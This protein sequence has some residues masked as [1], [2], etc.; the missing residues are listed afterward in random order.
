MIAAPEFWTLLPLKPCGDG[1]VAE[2]FEVSELERHQSGEVPEK[3]G[4][5]GH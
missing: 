5:E 2:G 3:K 4:Y 1:K